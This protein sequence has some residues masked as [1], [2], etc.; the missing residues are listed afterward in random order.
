MRVARWLS[1]TGTGQ[2]QLL[3]FREGGKELPGRF[4]SGNKPLWD[5]HGMIVYSGTYLLDS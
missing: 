3:G 4:F 1:D 5:R 2:C